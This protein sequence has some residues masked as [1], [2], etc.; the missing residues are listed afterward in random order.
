MRGHARS[1]E[2]RHARSCEVM[3]G[4]V[5]QTTVE[6]DKHAWVRLRVRLRLGLGQTAVEQTSTP[7]RA[8]EA[9]P[10]LA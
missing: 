7:L 4:D 3:T 6:A 1:C 5:W 2:V 10:S 8:T 9:A